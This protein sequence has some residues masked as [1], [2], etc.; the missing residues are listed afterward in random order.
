MQRQRRPAVSHGR[1]QRVDVKGGRNMRVT[2]AACA[3][4][5]QRAL[6]ARAGVLA[7]AY[8]AAVVDF[9]TCRCVA[10]RGVEMGAGDVAAAWAG[11]AAASLAGGRR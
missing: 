2:R 1:W 7:G 8:S 11:A 3:G 5:G 4:P 10:R 6:A 9:S